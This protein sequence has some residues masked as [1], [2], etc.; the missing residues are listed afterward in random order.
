MS[1]GWPEESLLP[2]QTVDDTDEGW[3]EDWGEDWGD[4]VTMTSTGSSARDRRITPRRSERQSANSV[5]VV[6]YQCIQV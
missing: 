3:S 2:E 6:S 1:E 5:S 4:P